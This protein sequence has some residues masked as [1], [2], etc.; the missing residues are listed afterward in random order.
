MGSKN[1]KTWTMKM[2]EVD[3]LISHDAGSLYDRVKLLIEI[4]EDSEFRA[5]CKARQEDPHTILDDK[6]GDTVSDFVTLTEVMER[7]PAKKQWEG[8]RLQKMIAEIRETDRLRRAEIAGKSNGQR[9]SWKEEYEALK[10][11]YEALEIEN[12]Q[13]RTEVQTLQ[14][15]FQKKLVPA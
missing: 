13:L 15:L 1:E 9:T 4:Y 7:F 10:K 12:L 6:V 3:E 11:R 14:T 2:A 5:H 8:N